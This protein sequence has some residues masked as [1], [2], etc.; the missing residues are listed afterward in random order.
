[1][2]IEGQLTNEVILTELGSRIA[3]RRLDFQLTQAKLAEEAG[4]SKRTVERIEAGATAQIS[5]MIRILRILK[6]LDGLDRLVP[7]SF[8]R[9]MDLL[10]LKSKKRQRAT[11]KKKKTSTKQWQWGE[12]L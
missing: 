7:E 9:P 4:I 5:T 11:R 1:M 12:K 3:R 2:K 6:L 10:K 8:P